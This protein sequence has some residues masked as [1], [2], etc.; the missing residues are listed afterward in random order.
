M[1]CKATRVRVKEKVYGEL[2][3]APESWAAGLPRRLRKMLLA[4]L[5]CVDLSGRIDFSEWASGLG[6][7]DF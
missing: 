3:T 2:E 7:R 5:S 6:W 1:G 4:A